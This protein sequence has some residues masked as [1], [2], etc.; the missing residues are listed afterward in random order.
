MKLFS[1][2]LWCFLAACAAV[3]PIKAAGAEALQSGD[4]VAICGDSITEQKLYSV[5]IEDYLLMCQPAPKLQAFQAGWGGETVAGFLLRMETDVLAFKPTVATL[6]YGM[7]DGRYQGKFGPLVPAAAEAYRKGLE[8]ILQGF[9]NNGVRFVVVGGPGAVDGDA[10]QQPGATGEVYN[11]T[12]AGISA[13]AKEV[14]EKNG[15]PY[16]NVHDPMMEAI[17]KAKAKYGATYLVARDGVHPSASGQLVMAYAFLKA[18]GCTGDIGTITMDFRSGKTEATAGHQVLAAKEGSADIESSRYPFCFSGEPKDPTGTL[19]MTEFVPFNQELNRFMFV[20]K[21]GPAGT[22]KVTWGDQTKEFA[23][24]DLAKGI[25]L[26]AEFPVN[27]F[28]KPF[29]T[30]ETAIRSQQ[31]FETPAIKSMLHVLPEWKRALP[32]SAEMYQTLT[33]QI[34]QKAQALR[35]ASAKAVVPVKHT[36][37]VAAK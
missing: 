22:V 24:A 13:V 28:S 33:G 29:A 19:G 7:N 6:C 16:A 12:L 17:A 36:I 2:G 18:L 20:L 23:S 1:L 32:E 15:L 31:D 30:V 11:E 25:N 26:A 10:F 9:K 37:S 14:A 21:N 4:L 3:L 34:L 35:E 5:F 27:P 8:S